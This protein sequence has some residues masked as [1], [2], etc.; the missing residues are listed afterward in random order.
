MYLL[1]Y[2]QDGRLPTVRLTFGA[3]T[4]FF[5]IA[6]LSR[7]PS[8]VIQSPDTSQGEEYLCGQS[9]MI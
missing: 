6:P 7:F 9:G 4:R 5:D 2:Y 1:T 3:V 8:A